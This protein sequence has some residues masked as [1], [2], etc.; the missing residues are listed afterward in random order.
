M[1]KTSIGLRYL[2]DLP[3]M[4]REMDLFLNAGFETFDLDLSTSGVRR[5]MHDSTCAERL[6]AAFAAFS[7]RGI[8]IDLAHAPYHPRVFGSEEQTRANLQDI[9][10]SIPVAGALGIPN[11]VV[12]PIFA[13]PHDPLYGHRDE[14][15]RMNIDMYRELVSIARECGVTICTENMFAT[16]E[17]GDAQLSFASVAQDLLDIIREVPEVGVCLDYGHAMLVNEDPTQMVHQFG[18]R[19]KALHLHCN[20]RRSDVHVSPFEC[21]RMPWDEFA[22]ALHE[23]QYQGAINLETHMF[24]YPAPDCMLPASFAY[25]HACAAQIAAWVR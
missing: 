14:L 25:L 16:A 12:H 1:L 9:R 4:I 11:L 5:M 24:Y 18:E 2:E 7:Q 13:Q 17:N 6:L 21:T 3:S 15:L 8:T 23:V 19:L 20:D 22:H 10:L